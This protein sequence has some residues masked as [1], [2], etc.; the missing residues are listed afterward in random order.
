MLCLLLIVNLFEC[1]C[2]LCV[3]QNNLLFNP[4][5]LSRLH[6][7]F[8]FIGNRNF[9]VSGWQLSF[10]SFA[11]F[12]HSLSLASM[13]SGLRLHLIVSFFIFF[14]SPRRYNIYVYDLSNCYILFIFLPCF[15]S[16]FFILCIKNNISHVF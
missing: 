16:F 14:V 4:F 1:V 12:I 7:F 13:L 5:G 11:H 6:S 10:F 15:L 8:L 9:I 3:I 2:E